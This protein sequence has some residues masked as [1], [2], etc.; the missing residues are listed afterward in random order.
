MW[1]KTRKHRIIN[2]LNLGTCG[3]S[4]VQLASGLHLGLLYLPQPTDH[5]TPAKKLGGH[6]YSKISPK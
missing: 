3:Q 4:I 6:T 5:S 1:F 2:G